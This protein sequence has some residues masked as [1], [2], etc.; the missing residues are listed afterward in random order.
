MCAQSLQ[1]QWVND[2]QYGIKMNDPIKGNKAQTLKLD[3]YVLNAG[4]FS[5][6]D[7]T[8]GSATSYYNRTG[9]NSNPYTQGYLSEEFSNSLFQQN[10]RLLFPIDYDEDYE[11][12]YPLI[13][14]MHGAGERGNCW[15]NNCYWGNSNW[16]PETNNPQAGPGTSQNLL[17]NDHNLVHGG[18]PHLDAVIRADGKLP[19]DPTLNSRDF[20]G[21]VL[22]PQSLNGW[23]T[24]GERIHLVRTIHNL[25]NQHNIDRNKVVVHG[26]SNGAEKLLTMVSLDPATFSGVLLMSPSNANAQINPDKVELA[27]IPIWVF[28]GGKDRNPTV[29]MT[30]IFARKF[31]ELGGSVRYTL[32]DNLGHGTWNKAYSET[33]FF[34]WIREKDKSDIHVFFGDSTICASNGNGAKLGVSWGF[35]KYQ[36]ELD[37]QIIS[38]ADSSI[39]I[40]EAPGIYR[41]RFS[42]FE[43][44]PSESDWN[45]WS[46]PVLITES[47]V[48]APTITA[49]NTLHLPDIN[50]VDTVG[51]LTTLDP[52]LYYTWYKGNDIV[53]DT[54]FYNV[55]AA[56]VFTVMSETFGGCPSVASEAVNVTFNAPATLASPT[57][58]N[59]E[60]TVANKIR[61]F[62]NDDS[63]EETGYEVYRSNTES[64]FYT[65]LALLPE[66][67]IS[68]LD[69]SVTSGSDYYYKIRAVAYD[70]VSP[71]TAA[72]FVASGTDSKAPT[73]PANFS[74]TDF[75]LTTASFSW[76]AATD[77]EG[78]K[79]YIIYFGSDSIKTGSTNTNFTVTQL[80]EGR[81]F[82]FTVKAIDY[83]GNL[84]LASNQANVVTILEGL[85]YEHSTNAYNSLTE[86]D[87][88]FIEFRG[89]LPNF[90][91]AGTTQDDF[92]SFKFDGY[93]NITEAGDY[94]FRSQSDDGSRVYIGGFDPESLNTN[95]VNDND[96]LHGCV[97]NEVYL[98]RS[99]AVGVYP[100][101]VLY[102]QRT[103]SQCLSVQFSKDGSTFQNIPDAMLK[104]GTIEVNTPPVAPFN[105]QATSLG[106]NTIEVGWDHAELIPDN[107]KVVVLGSSTAEG[108]GV[109]AIDSSWVGRL[110]HWLGARIAPIIHLPIW[111]LEALLRTI[112]CLME[113]LMAQILRLILIT[114]LRKH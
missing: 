48:S 6:R 25:M 108:V 5:F 34:S 53:S 97:V 47:V 28:Q 49:L 110:D 104:S 93:I 23:D 27:H 99:L 50:G 69:N 45:K 91:I 84:S 33:D 85:T 22:F 72:L 77:D 24:Q 103:S 29:N 100:I 62:W 111:L 1:A 46:K 36:W 80:A 21:F 74:V 95:L 68:Y 35:K 54:N 71:Y 55:K 64:G 38:G 18:K 16:K 19:N 51:L 57:A 82:A 70:K 83:F 32:Y 39:Y 67:A 52:S 96:G 87:W 20:P 107:T 113:P 63:L 11:E 3:K 79:E 10:F 60:L 109:A 26:L 37:G 102:F 8:A 7:T 101:T 76:D 41:C 112:F 2:Y 86:I 92:Y 90:S 59:S 66:D 78:I 94:R 13:V 56:G 31:E 106:L 43:A 58:V 17:N 42:R 75:S 88:S 65:F 81:T 4:T 73:A 12:G 89:T 98:T 44:N 15:N 9:W 40:A 114:T 61:L 14:M 105:L 30:Q